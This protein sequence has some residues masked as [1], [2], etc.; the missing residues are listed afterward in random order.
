MMTTPRSRT[1]APND[2]ERQIAADI[3][4]KCADKPIR[5]I[6]SAHHIVE[7]REAWNKQL[8]LTRPNGESPFL[9]K[10][11]GG[12]PE[13]MR[14]MVVRALET[15]GPQS[16]PDLRRVFEARGVF[17]SRG[18]VNDVIRSLARDGIVEAAGQVTALNGQPVSSWKMA[19]S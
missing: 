11:K 8:A 16:V 15:H 19:R 9:F 17:S 14:L 4:A 6:T 7:A 12:T 10:S 1:Y 2:E 3:I 18:Y 5:R 13:P